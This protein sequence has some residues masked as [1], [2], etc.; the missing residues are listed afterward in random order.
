VDKFITELKIPVKTYSYTIESEMIH[1][2]IVC[3]FKSA[4]IREKFFAEGDGLTLERAITIC[5]A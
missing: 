3:G 4:M 1:D 2:K 5:H